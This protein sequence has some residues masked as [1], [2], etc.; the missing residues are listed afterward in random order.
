MPPD[1]EIFAEQ[2]E[3]NVKFIEIYIKIIYN[4][5]I[6]NYKIRTGISDGTKRAGAKKKNTRRRIF[7]SQSNA[8]TGGFRYGKPA[9]Y[10]CGRGKRKDD[11]NR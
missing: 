11:R 8:E 9:S 6:D 5:I 4:D 1:K 7:K 10:S 2:T 3:K